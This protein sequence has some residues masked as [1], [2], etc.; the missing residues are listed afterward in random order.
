MLIYPHIIQKIRSDVCVADS[1]IKSRTHGVV[2]CD[3]ESL[4]AGVTHLLQTDAKVSLV[5]SNHGWNDYF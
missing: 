5:E 4:K 2:T 3:T 1:I